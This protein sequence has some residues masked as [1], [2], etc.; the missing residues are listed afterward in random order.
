MSSCCSSNLWLSGSKYNNSI[1]V[2]LVPFTSDSIFTS[3]SAS[4]QPPPQ[5]K[6][7]L[8][9][10]AKV[11]EWHGC[12]E[13]QYT[14]FSIQSHFFYYHN[15]MHRFNTYF[16]IGLS[17]VQS[18]LFWN[19]ERLSHYSALPVRRHVGA[20]GGVHKETT[21]RSSSDDTCGAKKER[22]PKK[23]SSKQVCKCLI[24]HQNQQK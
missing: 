20:Q 6:Y 3:L 10:S 4:L 7:L 24:C 22:Q 5:F 23:C 9:T 17:E 18:V 13:W 12:Y 11:T 16:C 8:S 15:R 21:G 2:A 1:A 19:V 14:Q